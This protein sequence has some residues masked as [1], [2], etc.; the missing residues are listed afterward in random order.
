VCVCVSVCTERERE[1]EDY[2]EKRK[3]FMRSVDINKCSCFGD[4]MV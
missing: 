1:R 2:F 4:G 3:R